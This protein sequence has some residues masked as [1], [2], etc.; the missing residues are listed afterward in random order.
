[1]PAL[2]TINTIQFNS[3]CIPFKAR[4]VGLVTRTAPSVLRAV[5]ICGWTD[6][7]LGR[8][9]GQA[10]IRHGTEPNVVAECLYKGEAPTKVNTP[11]VV[12]ATRHCIQ[13]REVRGLVG[14]PPAFSTR[15][16]AHPGFHRLL[17]LSASGSTSWHMMESNEGLRRTAMNRIC[18]H[19]SEPLN[20][21]S[22]SNVVKIIVKSS[23][24]IATNA[25]A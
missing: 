17:T 19:K 24:Y 4:D 7:E 20:P 10:D 8:G 6:F 1:M 13:R 5:I 16:W 2:P 25:S 23:R 21:H 15:S 3:I 12:S 14:A 18:S 9:N 22:H 11:T